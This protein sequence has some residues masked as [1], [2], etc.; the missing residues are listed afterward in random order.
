MN[1]RYPIF[2]DLSGKKSW[3]PAKATRSPFKVKL[4]RRR[5]SVTYMNP[6][7]VPV[8]EALAAGF[9]A[10]L[11]ASVIS[12]RPISKS[13]SSSSPTPKTTRP[14]FAWPKSNGILCNCVDDPENCRFSFGS[15]HRQGDL[16]IAIST[17]GWA[18]AVAVRL[19]EWLQREIGPEYAAFLRM[20]KD[21]RP[22]ITTQIPDFAARR[23]L[24]YRIV[25]SDILA[26][27]APAKP[28]KPSK[29][30]VKWSPSAS[31]ALPVLIFAA[32]PPSINERH[33]AAECP[34]PVTC[35]CRAYRSGPKVH[36]LALRN[37]QSRA[38]PSSHALRFQ[39]RRDKS[40]LR[41]A[42]LFRSPQHFHTRHAANR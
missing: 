22:Q 14:S 9:L 29:P 8:I 23:D 40:R 7:A 10:A 42:N 21:V 18:P 6:R 12:F 35:R 16:T 26:G 31:A 33:S 36:A 30:S 20:L 41:T 27:F 39:L 17:N 38:V 37:T 19:K 2:L 34:R 32:I 15:L 13:A 28:S 11:G 1:F 24:W 5:S 25:D 4:G 3:L